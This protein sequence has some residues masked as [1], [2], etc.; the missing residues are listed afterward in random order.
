M[1]LLK[2]IQLIGAEGRPFLLDVYFDNQQTNQ[3]VIIFSHG[4]KGFKDW[5]HWSQ[6]AASFV[7]AGYVFLAFNF[8]H[9]GTTTA[10]P[11]DFEDLEAFGHNNFSKELLDLNVVLDW[12]FSDECD[13][14]S[15]TY[16]LNRIGLIGHSRGGALSII[17]A[18]NDDRVKALSTW[19]SVNTLDY[20]WGAEGFLDQWK[21]DGVYYVLNGRTGQQMPLYYQMYEDFVAHQPAFDTREVLKKFD[22]PYLIVHGT[23]DPGVDFQSAK[24]LHGWAKNSRLAPIEGADHVFNGR[25]PF[26]DTDLPENTRKLVE[27]T[28]GFFDEEL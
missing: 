9:N 10:S 8:S 24:D 6:I 2:N 1:E 16:D 12:L 26:T 23:E 17:K 4:F 5:G 3:P 15:D 14:P 28:V 22:K 11:L 27:V 25:H 21:E 19:A 20:A 13:I 7:E 18:G